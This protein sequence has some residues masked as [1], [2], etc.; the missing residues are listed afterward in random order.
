MIAKYLE[1]T[2]GEKLFVVVKRIGEEIQHLEKIQDGHKKRFIFFYLNL[3]KN[4][5]KW[6]ASKDR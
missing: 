5:K 4:G 2:G 1:I 3:N 6:K